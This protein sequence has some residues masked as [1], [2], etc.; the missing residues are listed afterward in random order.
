MSEYDGPL[1]TEAIA[2]IGMAGRFPGARNIEAFWENLC[3][4][5]ES[6][7]DLDETGLRAVGVPEHVLADP[8]YVRRAAVLDGHDE[9]DAEFF[10]FPPAMAAAMDPQQRLFLECCWHALEDAGHD[11]ARYDG[12][13]GVFASGSFSGYLAYHLLSHRD[14]REILGSGTSTELIQTLATNDLNFLA[15]RAAHT[16]DLRGPALTVQTACS[17]SL[18]ALHLACQSLLCG[19][20][21]MALAG[22]ISVKVPHRAGYVYDSDSMMSADGRCRP[23]D[24]AANGTVFGSGGG[25][26]LLKRLSDALADG[27]HVRAVVRGSAVNNDGSL[28]MSYS[29]PSV[30][31]QAAVVAEALAVAGVEPDSVSYVEAHGTGTALGDPIEVAALRKALDADGTR[32]E[33]CALGSAKGNIGHLE[34]A[35]GITGLIKTVLALE[36]RLLPGTA[37]F[38]SPNPELHLDGTPFAIQHRLEK[39][40]GEAPLRAGVSSLGVGGTNAHV[41]LQEAPPVAAD[42][43]DRVVRP[44]VLLVS[45]GS[46]DA[47]R[48]ARENLAQHLRREPAADLAD[49]AFTLAEG[50]RTFP[51]RHAVAATTPQQAAE[52]LELEAGG[53]KALGTGPSTVL[54]LPGQGAQYPGMTR[55]LYRADKVFRH[56]VDH[57]LGLFASHGL[58]GLGDVLFGS[59]EQLLRRT[60]HAQA[61]LLTVEYALART[62]ESYGLRPDAVAGHSVGEYTA[63]CLAGVMD[64]PDAVRL[65]AARGRVMA[66][67][68]PGAM[69]AVRL[70]EA[71]TTGLLEGTRIEVSAVNEPRGTVL[72]GPGDEVEELDRELRA[73]GV[74]TRLLHTA[75]AFHTAALAEAADRFAESFAGVRL[76]PPSIPLVSNIT[77]DWMTDAEATDPLRWARQIRLPVRWADST[78]LLLSEPGRLLIETGPGRSL[79]TTARRAAGWSPEHHRAVQTV[80]HPADTG[81]DHLTLLTGLGRAWASGAPVDWSRARD[82]RPRRRVPLPGHPFRR[83]RHWRDSAYAT[84]TGPRKAPDVQPVQEHSRPAVRASDA[85][86]ADPS[87]EELL[88]AVFAEVLGFEEIGRHDSFF[89]LGG[90]SVLATQ[91]A[92]RARARGLDFRPRDMFENPTIARLAQ[93]AVPRAEPATA[94]ADAYSDPTAALP[95]NPGQAR[96]VAAP[97][98]GLEEAEASA[99][100][101]DDSV[102][103]DLV[104]EALGHVV[105]HHDVLGLRLCRL[106]GGWEQRPAAIAWLPVHRLADIDDRSARENLWG[107]AGDTDGHAALNVGLSERHRRLVLLPH[108]AF[109]DRRSVRILAD[110]LRTACRQLLHDRP[111]ELPAATTPWRTWTARRSAGEKPTPDERRYWL[112]LLGRADPDPLPPARGPVEPRRARLTLDGTAS[113]AVVGR[114]RASRVLVAD[115]VLAATANALNTQLG[116]RG[117]LIDVTG[118]TRATPETG[119]DLSRTLG[120]FSTEHPVRVDPGPTALTPPYIRELLRGV[121]RRGLGYEALRHTDGATTPPLADLPQAE[122]LFADLGALGSATD[123]ATG[124]LRPLTADWTGPAAVPGA[125][126]HAVEVRSYQ[127]DGLLTV[128]C[129]YDATRWDERQADAILARIE[130]ALVAPAG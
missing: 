110:D 117:R 96:R 14:P 59:D 114:A 10:G 18:V 28:K 90:D 25:V 89:D 24:A 107:A 15:T 52:A 86:T 94:P 111:V 98:A 30:E 1:E 50:R 29:A 75:H 31:M 106:D 120:A 122:V 54:L 19:E 104:E 97:H 4:G 82:G 62:L 20:S 13:I 42:A 60:D 81:D 58:T 124:P 88:T 55:G 63:A 17:S 45:A 33:P 32:T 95:L 22:G 71:E 128:D 79:L 44:E 27:D 85:T 109:L 6:L 49:V 125:L 5:R 9:F 66:A 46:A 26:V 69:L 67:A 121:P 91:I 99:F 53:S 40:T 78:A 8:G 11:P 87:A 103:A 74:S 61:A 47:L 93:I 84:D 64:L 48:E 129:W 36:H 127:C 112:D 23:F 119:F 73:R 34:A 56:E 12:P 41:V 57:C 43:G 51:Y 105:A 37:H 39:W 16:L 108:P 113:R 21:D 3:A 76:A 35:S 115:V 7:E 68:P 130:E 77:G 100:S 38:T 101:V 2:V 70:P 123:P 92:S 116:A 83:T 80:R 65:V 126:R 118:S 72:G 102:T